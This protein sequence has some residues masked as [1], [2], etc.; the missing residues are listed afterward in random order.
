MTRLEIEDDVEDGIGRGSLVV[1][2]LHSPREKVWGK[3]V[4]LRTLGVT[5]RGI[6]LSSFED[7]VSEV[8]S[9][10]DEMTMGLAM[11]FY[12]THRIE[13]I[14]LDETVG[15]ARSC[16]VCSLHSCRIGSVRHPNGDVGV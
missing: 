14:I 1:L 11:L 8:R 15:A 5:I 12:P 6:D 13:K 3:I 10:T 4:Q 2:S 9:G 16:P 7:W